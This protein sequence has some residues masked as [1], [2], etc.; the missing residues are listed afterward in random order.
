[1]ASL[2]LVAVAVANVLSSWGELAL[3]LANRV[4]AAAAAECAIADIW[5]RVL[6]LLMNSYRMRA[7]C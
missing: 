6:F 4:L 3:L 1:M 2:K 7:A 5:R